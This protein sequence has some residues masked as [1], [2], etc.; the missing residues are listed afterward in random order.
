MGGVRALVLITDGRFDYL[1]ECVRSLRENVDLGW[2]D[3]RVCVFDAAGGQRL[4]LPGFDVIHHEKRSG[5]AAAVRSGWEAV[6]GAEFVFHVEE[7]FTFDEPVDLEGMSNVLYRRQH[8]AQMCLLRGPWSPE[9]HAAGGIVEMHPADYR[10]R[11]DLYGRYW[12]EHDRLFSLNP[13]LIPGHIVDRGWPDTNEAGFTEQLLCHGYRFAYWG[14]GKPQVTH[15]GVEGGMGSP[16][17]K[18]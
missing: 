11:S 13:C 16:G 3:R 5:L 15:I 12:L 4:E 10:Q 7:D 1:A 14:D 18:P 8:V 6:N 9:E 2:F 17:W